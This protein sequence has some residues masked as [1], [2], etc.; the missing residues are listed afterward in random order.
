MLSAAIIGCGKIATKFANDPLM[1]DDVFTHAEA[2]V[3]CS[4]T[5]LIAVADIDPLQARACAEQWEIPYWF[6]SVHEMLERIQPEIVSICTPD[7]T[8]AQ[9]AKDMLRN[10][11]NLRGLL[12]EKPLAQTE[13]EALD[14][15]ELARSRGVVLAVVFMR[16]YAENVRA[17]QVLIQSGELGTV[18]FVQGLYGKGVRHNGCHWLDM[19]RML[20]GDVAWVEAWDRLQDSTVDPTLDVRIGLDQGAVAMLNGV[21]AD[22]YTLF[23]MDI[24]ASKGRIRLTES[25]HRV[26]LFKVGS[27]SRHTGYNELR[28]LNHDFGQRRDMLLHA[29]EDLVE[30]LSAGRP[31]ACNGEDGIAVARITDA[32]MQSACLKKR[33]R[34]Y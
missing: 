2:Y 17:V 18:E 21:R 31:P 3:R 6:T 12:I 10:N 27:S 11:R 28:V 15:V 1:K 26:E 9:I 23:E 19:L 8:H 30:S 4:D 33:M 20:V 13:R 14:L 24:L 5:Q 29:V 16:R 25:C 34:L 22:Q 7:G 32:C